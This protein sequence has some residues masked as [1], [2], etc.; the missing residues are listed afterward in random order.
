MGGF[1]S[2]KAWMTLISSVSL[3]ASLVYLVH[4]QQKLEKKVMRATIELENQQRVK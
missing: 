3:T 4:S 2:K 1:G